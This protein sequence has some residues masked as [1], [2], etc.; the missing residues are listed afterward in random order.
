MGKEAAKLLARLA[1][2]ATMIAAKTVPIASIAAKKSAIFTG[3][4]FA[5][6][7]LGKTG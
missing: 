4:F 1:A 5:Q 3:T 7:I 2:N 6:Y